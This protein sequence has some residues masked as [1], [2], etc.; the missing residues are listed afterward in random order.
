M[1][2]QRNAP[3][4]CGS[5]SKYKHCCEGKKTQQPIWLGV[6]IALVIVGAALIAWSSIGHSGSQ[7]NAQGKVWSE[8][9]QHYH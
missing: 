2:P 8:E 4:P 9:H 7:T 1:K 3:C 5:G 6:L